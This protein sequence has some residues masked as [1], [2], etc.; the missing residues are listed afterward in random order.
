LFRRVLQP[1]HQILSIKYFT[2]RVS[3]TERDP[4]SPS[5]RI[6]GYVPSKVIYPKSRSIMVTSSV[7]K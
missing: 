1:K 6:H 5:A 3:E 2:A 4:R 7:T